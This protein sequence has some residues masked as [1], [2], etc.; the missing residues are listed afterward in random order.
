MYIRNHASGPK[1]PRPRSASEF[2]VYF[3]RGGKCGCAAFS[4][5]SQL[6]TV[7]FTERS[8]GE[9]TKI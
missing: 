6:E 4:S 7:T 3:R 8:R 5:P 1:W 9:P 2:V